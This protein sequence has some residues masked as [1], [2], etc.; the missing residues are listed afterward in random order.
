MFSSDAIDTSTRP[1]MQAVDNW[2]L[3]YKGSWLV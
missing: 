3:L 1:E 2:D